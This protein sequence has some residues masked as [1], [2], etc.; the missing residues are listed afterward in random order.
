M[1]DRPPVRPRPG[2]PATSRSGTCPAHTA[3]SRSS[4][5]SLGPPVRLAEPSWIGAHERGA[6]LEIGGLATALRPAECSTIASG[7]GLLVGVLG[8]AATRQHHRAVVHRVVEGERASTSPSRI[9]TVTHTGASTR[10]AAWRCRG[11][12]QVQRVVGT[13]GHRQHA[14]GI[15]HEADVSDIR[16]VEDRARSPVVGSTIGDRRTAARYEVGRR[17]WRPWSS[18]RMS[19]RRFRCRQRVGHH[20]SMPSSNSS[21]RATTGPRSSARASRR[22]PRVREGTATAGVVQHP[23]TSAA[24]RYCSASSRVV[25]EPRSADRHRARSPAPPPRARRSGL[26]VEAAHQASATAASGRRRARSTAN[27]SGSL[28]TG[29]TARSS[30]SSPSGTTPTTLVSGAELLDT[31]DSRRRRRRQRWSSPAGRRAHVRRRRSTARRP[32]APRGRSPGARCRGFGEH[33]RL[34]LD[35]CDE[36]ASSAQAR[37]EVEALL[38]P[39]ELLHAG[40]LTDRF[41]STTTALSSPSR[42]SRSTGPM[43]VGYSRRTSRVV[44]QRS[45]AWRAPGAPPP[46]RPWPGPGRRRARSSS[47]ARSRAARSRAPR[48]PGSCTRCGRRPRARRMGIHPVQRLVGLGIR[49]GWRSSRRP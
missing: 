41:T 42:H 19:R 36:H 44:A 9:V 48:R 29:A 15:H 22:R 13:P 32:E 31:N 43:S 21:S 30:R 18:C 10:R 33:L 26:L 3:R 35:A 39:D 20:R 47:R 28:P 6:G 12:V 7:A 34:R 25:V 40:D 5:S 24:V 2:S 23:G 27:G 11:T 49:R 45:R 8:A 1:R 14:A 16:L 46:R 17:T 37:V 38:I 4:S